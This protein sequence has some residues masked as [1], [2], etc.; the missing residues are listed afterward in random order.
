MQQDS[1]AEWGMLWSSYVPQKCF[2]TKNVVLPPSIMETIL[3]ITAEGKGKKKETQTKQ[4]KKK[5]RKLAGRL[6]DI[7][8]MQDNSVI[9]HLW[10]EFLQGFKALFSRTWMCCVLSWF[11]LFGSVGYRYL[12]VGPELG[13][14]VGSVQNRLRH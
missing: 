14:L 4:N 6:P 10:P 1:G 8:V 11:Q 5:G 13:L 12:S 3:G 2:L 9:V 7:D